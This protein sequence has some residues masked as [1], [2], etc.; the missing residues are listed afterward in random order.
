M[1]LHARVLGKNVPCCGEKR[2]QSFFSPDIFAKVSGKEKGG[3]GE[4]EK[5]GR[6]SENRLK[7]FAGA[8][9]FRSANTFNFPPLGRN[10]ERNF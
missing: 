3:Q 10:G 8:C 9:Y 6:R 2:E 7:N 4:K 5:L 1:M